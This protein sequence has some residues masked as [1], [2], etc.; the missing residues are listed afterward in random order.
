MDETAAT[1]KHMN[2]NSKSNPEV[3]FSIILS[4]LMI[5]AGVLAIKVPLAT[6]IEV[7]NID[8]T[9]LVAWLLIFSGATHLAYAWHTRG[10]GGF[11]LGILLG[12]DYAGAGVYIRLHPLLNLNLLL[13]VLI[14]YLV[15][16]S[17]LEFMLSYRL[18]P[19]VGSSWLRSDGMV[20]LALA[21]IL[22]VITRISWPVS[23]P[24]VIGV[25][26]GFSMLFSGLARLM[27]A[28]APRRR[29]KPPDRETVEPE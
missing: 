12:V 13:F 25:L 28:L 15:V 11:W 9:K 21:I 19:L 22:A 8:V 20:T 3:T 5:V 29:A 4:G 2:E 18:Q 16:E 6:N 7:T 27:V 24:W 10:A 26:V 1:Q 14:V 23:F 17:I